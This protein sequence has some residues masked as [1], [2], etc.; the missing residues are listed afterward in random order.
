MVEKYRQERHWKKNLRKVPN[1]ILEKVGNLSQDKLVVACVLVVPGAA[2]RSGRFR[3]LDIRLDGDNVSFSERLV[4]KSA[5]GKYSYWNLHGREIVRRDLPMVAKTYS[6]EVPNYGDWYNGSHE[7]L[8]TRDVYQ[9][10]FLPPKAVELSISLLKN[11][12]GKDSNFLFKFCVEEV[13]DR[14]AVDFSESLLWNLNLLQENVGN[15]DIFRRDADHTE[16]QQTISVYWEILPPGEGDETL[17]KILSKFRQ[18]T[19]EVKQRLMARYRL[20]ES[21]NPVAYISGTSG[22]QRYFGAKF[23]HDLIVFENLE[24]GN[25]IYVMFE[26]WEELSKLSRLELLKHH[27]PSFI[28]I[29]HRPGWEEVLKRLVRDRVRSAA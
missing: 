22:F 21:L 12:S 26:D 27:R 17:E 5:V 23:Q 10:D 16:Y 4:P 14:T 7:V 13:L 15:V 28:R 9:R 29:I 25:A 8:W 2:I 6:V 11:E 19:E 24:Y 1:R 20:L 3:H 18:P